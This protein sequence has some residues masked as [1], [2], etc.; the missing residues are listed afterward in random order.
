M[1]ELLTQMFKHGRLPWLTKGVS[2]LLCVYM[3]YAVLP[4]RGKMFNI[5]MFKYMNIFP[6]ALF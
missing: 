4:H 1:N 6:F 3:L 5:Q 2:Y